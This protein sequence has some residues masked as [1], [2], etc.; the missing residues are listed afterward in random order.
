[1]ASLADS[2]LLVVRTKKTLRDILEKT[3]NEIKTSGMK[4]VS[5]VVNDIQSDSKQ[6]G[7]GE[8]YGYTAEK[9]Q[10]RK[11]LFRRKKSS[12]N[13]KDQNSGY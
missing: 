4:G 5:L 13:R 7:F 6:Y 10:S 12:S 3:I 11:H 9:R 1:L 2:C 8:K